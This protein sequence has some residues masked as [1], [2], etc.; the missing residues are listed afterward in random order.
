[1]DLLQLQNMLPGY[2][3]LDPLE[4]CEPNPIVRS[5]GLA[6]VVL[7]VRTPQPITSPNQAATKLAV[8]VDLAAAQNLAAVFDRIVRTLAQMQPQ[9]SA[10]PN[11]VQTRV[12][13]P[14]SSKPKD[15]R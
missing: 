15:R 5:D 6:R 9:E 14:R 3:I 11:G 2:E 8:H 10:A 1:M 13:P 7:V 4:G 12:L